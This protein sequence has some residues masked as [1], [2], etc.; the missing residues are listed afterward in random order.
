MNALIACATTCLS[1]FC[2]K[3]GVNYVQNPSNNSAFCTIFDHN[4]VQNAEISLARSKRMREVN[5]TN[6]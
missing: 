3:F 4:Y 2:T 5:L 1:A 6:L